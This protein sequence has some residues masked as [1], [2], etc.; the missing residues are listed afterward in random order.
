MS[1]THISTKDKP[2]DY[3]AIETAKP[4]EPLFAIQGGDPLGPKTVQFWA[5]EARK[6]ARE[7][8]D[9][10]ERDRLL[11]KASMAEEVVW[12]M[13]DY[14]AGVEAVPGVRSNYADDGPT[15]PGDPT[16]RIKTRAAL[17]AGVGR[18]NNA[19]G[20][21][22]EVEETLAKIEQHPEAQAVILN[23]IDELKD[24]AAL[25]EPRRGNVRS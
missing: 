11:R 22:K 6:L 14:Q 12:A 8:D 25:I 19:I 2:G 18:L 10:K 5:D 17:I 13:K 24:A 16:D 1:E 3:D 23:G 15:L 20:I 9:E 7:T 21:A 4:D